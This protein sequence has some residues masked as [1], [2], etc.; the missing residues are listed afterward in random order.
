MFRSHHWQQWEP[1]TACKCNVMEVGVQVVVHRPRDAIL[2]SHSQLR[3]STVPWRVHSVRHASRVTVNV[4]RRPILLL[5]YPKARR[6]Y[7]PFQSRIPSSKAGPAIS[8]RSAPR[9]F[10]TTVFCVVTQKGPF[11]E[12]QDCLVRVYNYD[13]FDVCVNCLVSLGPPIGFNPPSDRYLSS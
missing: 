12:L 3:A 1:R 4:G 2:V 9:T 8:W 5:H 11:V 10:L 7:Q 6:A 13:Q